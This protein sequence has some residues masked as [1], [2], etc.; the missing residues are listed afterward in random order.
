MSLETEFVRSL[1]MLQLPKAISRDLH[2]GLL[3]FSV[4]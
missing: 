3:S 4:S 1:G 2:G